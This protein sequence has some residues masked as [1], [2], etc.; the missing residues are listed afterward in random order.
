M[1]ML[2]FHNPDEENGYL[3]NWYHSEFVINNITYSS[4][5]Q[6]MMCMKAKCFDDFEMVDKIMSTNDV[7]KIKQYGREVNGY[8]ENVWAGIRQI[9]V[10]EGLL[11]KFSQNE[12]LREQLLSTG[13]AILVECALKDR[14]WGI[15]RAMNDPQIFD[16]N[17]WNGQNLLG[18][19]LMLVRKKL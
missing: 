7:A 2:A 4:M 19:T 5:E 8:N 17:S 1:K 6:Y 3:S 11:A 13:D 9:I 12:I 16:I 14:I 15:G 10:Y 18:Y